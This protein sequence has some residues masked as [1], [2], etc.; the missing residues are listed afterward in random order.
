VEAFVLL[1]QGLIGPQA[2]LRRPS[3]SHLPNTTVTV[4]TWKSRDRNNSIT[5][6]K[7]LKQREEPS[8][9]PI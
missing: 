8:A 3:S 7:L 9:Q 1:L 5:A 4:T 2:E 6:K